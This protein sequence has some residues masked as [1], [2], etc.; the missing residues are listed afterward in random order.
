MRNCVWTTI[1]Q[2]LERSLLVLPTGPS[3]RSAR[4]AIGSLDG[5]IAQ[6]L[7]TEHCDRRRLGLRRSFQQP[8]R[9]T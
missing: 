4:P 2:G 8:R 3:T 6:I 7:M 5:V 1:E 9:V